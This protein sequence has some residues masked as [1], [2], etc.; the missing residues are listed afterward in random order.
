MA[1]RNQVQRQLGNFN[2]L[3]S[4]DGASMQEAY[5]ELES[6]QVWQ[7]N[8]GEVFQRIVISTSSVVIFEGVL[9]D[10][11]RVKFPINKLAV[12]DTEYKAW[13]ITNLNTERV[14]GNLNFVSNRAT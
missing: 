4:A 7:S 6:A 14:R 13:K 8:P 9:P 3:Y 11:T 1:G 10:L 5:F 12:L 2:A